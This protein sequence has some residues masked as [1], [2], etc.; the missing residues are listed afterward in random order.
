M[1][2]APMPPTQPEPS[3]EKASNDLFDAFA[4]PGPSEAPAISSGPSEEQKKAAES[5]T[6]SLGDLYAQNTQSQM[7]NAF[8]GFGGGFPQAAPQ[9]QFQAPPQT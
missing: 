8:G 9:Q 4:T 3:P 7:N 5:L 6:S 2:S 1:G